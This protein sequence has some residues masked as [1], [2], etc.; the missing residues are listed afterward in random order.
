MNPIFSPPRHQE[1]Q[2]LQ[3][4]SNSKAGGKSGISVAI[5]NALHHPRK[6]RAFLVP[7]CLG[8]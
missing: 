4:Q 8:G 6:M 2:G 1:H 7:W 3:F 5:S